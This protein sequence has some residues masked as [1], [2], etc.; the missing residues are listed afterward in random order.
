[1]IE[2]FKG[3]KVEELAQVT[4]KLD[5]G[6]VRIGNIAREEMQETYW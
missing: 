1:M 5:G 6:K 4:L 3:Q 2:D